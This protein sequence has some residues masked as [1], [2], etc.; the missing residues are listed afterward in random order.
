MSDNGATL[1][2]RASFD[3]TQLL[4]A[5]RS[6][7]ITDR[8]R[9]GR[10]NLRTHPIDNVEPEIPADRDDGIFVEAAGEA[11]GGWRV[12]ITIADVAGHVSM[13]N[14]LARVAFERGFTIYRHPMIDSMFPKPLEDR[15]SLE[16]G[17]ERLG[18]T[19]T[20]DLDR[21]Y[22]PR[23]VAFEPVLTHPEAID[24]AGAETRMEHDPEFQLMR[25]IARGVRHRYYGAGNAVWEEMREE[26]P[27]PVNITE[28][29]LAATKMV[30]TYMLLANDAVAH[31][32]AETG[33][34]FLYRNFEPTGKDGEGKGEVARAYYSTQCT[35][36]AELRKM[37]LHGPYCHFTSP[38]RRGADFLNG[39]MVHYAMD[40]LRETEQE[41]RRIHPQLSVERLHSLLWEKGPALL[42]DS[43]TGNAGTFWQS[44]LD[45]CGQAGAPSTHLQMTHVK[46]LSAML[47]ARPL[48][49][50]RETLENYANHINQLTQHERVLADMPQMRDTRK[51]VEQFEKKLHKLEQITE[52]SAAR[53][54][55]DEFTHAMRDAAKTGLLPPALLNEALKRLEEGRIDLAKVAYHGLI[56]AHFSNDT[57]WI[58]LKKAL[59]T[60]IKHNPTAVNSVLEIAQTES[61]IPA[62][63]LTIAQV[64]LPVE[65]DQSLP[66]EARA[67]VAALLSFRPPGEE[68]LIAAPYYSI[69][70][71]Q[72]SSLSHAKYSFIEHFAFGQLKPV[73]QS[74]IPNLLYARLNQSEGSKQTLLEGMAVEMGA[75]FSSQL[76]HS[77]TG[78]PMAQVSLE[79]G[80]LTEMLSVTATASTPERAMERAVKRLLSKPAFKD[81]GSFLSPMEMQQLIHP[82]T[83]LRNRAHSEHIAVDI[84]VREVRLKG[85]NGHTAHVRLLWPDGQWKQYEGDG[86]NRRRAINMACTEA[87]L[88]LG[89]LPG[90]KQQRTARSWITEIINPGEQRFLGK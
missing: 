30:E 31:F 9:L 75:Q 52:E 81:V 77:K 70:N 22:Q 33:L 16:N 68:T 11:G 32:F 87:L 49:F 5:S 54:M 78:K 74:A 80:Q 1:F 85:R 45:L 35:E 71:D 88:H 56:A 19:V 72:R 36:H 82:D 2:Q 7:N 17:Q 50:S 83:E 79:G 29:K 62:H 63:A 18:L 66:H 24:Y 58:I 28:A 26:R 21:D 23:H 38:I 89:W 48:P 53:K 65:S 86:P 12:H 59:C 15:L 27:L 44:L 34:P 60:A 61:A 4:A 42:R 69:G 6:G 57:A 55:P 13:T 40:W 73:D 14:P 20:I 41:L 76:R 25:D 84:D 90:N 46:K 67:V 8:Q 47:I 10:R 39:H 64:S 51:T 3:S 37:G 43:Q